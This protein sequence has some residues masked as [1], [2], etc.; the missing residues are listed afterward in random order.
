MRSCSAEVYEAGLLSELKPPITDLAPYRKRPSRSGGNPR[1]RPSSASGATLEQSR[2][3]GVSEADLPQ[4]YP[5]LRAADL[6]NAWSYV[7]DH[8]FARLYRGCVGGAV[9][10]A[11][12]H[13]GIK[14]QVDGPDQE[15]AISRRRDGRLDQPEVGFL[16]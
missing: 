14:R 4:A 8:H 3:L 16:E 15:F 12:P 9:V 6:V 10:H 11:Q 2:R 7:A 1:R 13:S 5:G